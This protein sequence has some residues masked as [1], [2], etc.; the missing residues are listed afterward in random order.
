MLA[1]AQT[2]WGAYIIFGVRIV[3]LG[4]EIAVARNRGSQRASPRY[5]RRCFEIRHALSVC[6]DK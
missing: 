5:E 6:T 3:L 1:I 4:T 2:D